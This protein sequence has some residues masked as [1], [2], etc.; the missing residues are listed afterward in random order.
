VF[1]KRRPTSCAESFRELSSFYSVNFL[2]VRFKLFSSNFLIT[3]SIKHLDTENVTCG[4]LGFHSSEDD[5]LG[6]DAVG[7]KRSLLSTSSALPPKL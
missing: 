6:S 2:C 3:R 7:S 5:I 4:I 1:I